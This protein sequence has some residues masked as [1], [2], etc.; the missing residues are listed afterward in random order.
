MKLFGDWLGISGCEREIEGWC[1]PV[2]VLTMLRKSSCS[3]K[4]GSGADMHPAVVTSGTCCCWFF[5]QQ[6]F[7][8]GYPS[9]MVGA[10]ATEHCSFKSRLENN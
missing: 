3:W 7:S 10:A 1:L 5:V 6:P 4:R 2:L 8:A 9:L